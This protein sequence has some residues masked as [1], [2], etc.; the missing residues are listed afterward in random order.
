MDNSP[1]EVIEEAEE[2]FTKYL[3]KSKELIHQ[4]KIQIIQ[5]IHADLCRVEEA[6]VAMQ[7]KLKILKAKNSYTNKTLKLM[8]DSKIIPIIIALK[9]TLRYEL[10]E[11]EE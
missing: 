10:Q 4:K 6:M 7:V 1:K 5:E 2:Y 11:I 9:T 8:E 3:I